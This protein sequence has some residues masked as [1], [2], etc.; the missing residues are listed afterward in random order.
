MRIGKRII[1]WTATAIILASGAAAVQFFWPHPLPPAPELASLQASVEEGAYLA[2]QGNCAACH[3]RPGGAQYAG[4]LAFK[5]DFG[6]LYSTNITSD[7]R[8]GIGAWSFAQF[9]RAMKHGVRDD[10]AH[11]YPA[12]P[13]THFAKLSDKDIAALFLHFR[14]VPAVA[15][16]N[17]ANAM[18]FPFGERGLLYFW[19][20]MFHDGSTRFASVPARGKAYN[21]GAYLVQSIAHCGAC[22]SPRN[23]LGGQSDPL[24]LS[25]GTYYDKVGNG[26]YRPWAAVDL[27]PG[28]HGLSHWN[29]A[30]MK[31]YL[32]TGINRHTVVHGPMNEVV[33]ATAKMRPSDLDAVA[34]YLTEMKGSGSRPIWTGWSPLSSQFVEGETVYTVQCGTCHLPNG[35]GDKVL[36]V[37]LHRNPVVQA[38]NPASL[39]NVILYGPHLPGPPFV[40]NRTRMKPL[41]K[42]MSDEDIAAVATYVRGSFENRASAVSADQVAAQ[43]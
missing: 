22:H 33:A 15:Q 21:R 6:T 32:Q 10:G 36:G 28:P 23:P 38:E 34:T 30:D 11:L 13:Y 24:S 26:L 9:Y 18:T 42:R 41:G 29:R 31:A 8:H 5:T 43:R 35:K 20:R 25:G 19:K 40:V 2:A 12:F 3:T 7:K 27:T 16:A 39:I 14:T 4:G 1:G 37:S 17:R